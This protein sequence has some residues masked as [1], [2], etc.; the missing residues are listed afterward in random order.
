LQVT[1]KTGKLAE[2]LE[3][4]EPD[5][6]PD[7]VTKYFKGGEEITDAVHSNGSNFKL[8]AGKTKLFRIRIEAPGS[9]ETTCVIPAI[10]SMSLDGDFATVRVNKPNLLCP[11]PI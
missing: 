1:N 11:A 10:S 4:S 8:G 7:W 9:L 3:L 2:A 5:A 6:E